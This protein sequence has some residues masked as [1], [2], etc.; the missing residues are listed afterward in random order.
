MVIRKHR[1]SGFTDTRLDQLLRSNGIKTVVLAGMM[2]HGSVESTAREAA[3]RDYYLV[4]AKDAVATP[5]DAADLHS[6]SLRSLENHFG[7]V[8]PSGKI[9]DIWHSNM[10]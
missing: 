9:A 5:D 3:M 7:M 10:R 6:V 4:I 1:F 8:K 2:T